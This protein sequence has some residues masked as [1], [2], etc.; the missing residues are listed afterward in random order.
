MDINWV[1]GPFDRIQTQIPAWA[2]LGVC[3]AA[4]PILLHLPTHL[5]L[6]KFA[7]LSRPGK[8]DPP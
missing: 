1:Y 5:L 2:Y 8:G 6:S 7:R 4:Y 3:M